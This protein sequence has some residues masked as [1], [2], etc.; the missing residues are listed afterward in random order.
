MA[1][2]IFRSALSAARANGDPAAR[3]SATDTATA[4]AGVKLSG[5]SVIVGSMAYPPRRPVSA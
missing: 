3:R 5:G 2:M 4:S 1:V